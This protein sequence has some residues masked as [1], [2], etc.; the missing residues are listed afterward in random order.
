MPDND[1]LSIV[2]PTLNAEKDLA[3]C[4]AA[5]VPAVVDGLVKDVVI[6]DGGSS[7]RTLKIADQ[8]GA[9]AIHTDAGRGGQFAEGA[10]A[11]KG[12]WLLFLHADTV[13]APGWHSDAMAFMEA[14]DTGRRNACAAAFGFALDDDG[15]APRFVESMV[16]VR[17]GLMKLPYG[18]QG[19]LISRALYS[20]IGGYKPMAMMED[21]DIVR[22]LGSRRVT[23]L[24]AKAVTSA[25]RYRRDGYFR[26]IAR[27]QLC[28]ASYAVGVSPDRIRR[29][30]AKRS[31]E[32]GQTGEPREGGGRGAGPFKGRD[33]A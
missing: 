7:D 26:R 15:F 16:G 25:Q 11:A 27:N 13:L 19:L 12:Q 24:R 29:L 17:S 3:R 20:E 31:D 6:A 30:Y 33:Q 32:P 18:D 4:L 5:L 23:T 21:V 10:K 8:A 9:K 28:L 14:V 2:I 22:R 1:M